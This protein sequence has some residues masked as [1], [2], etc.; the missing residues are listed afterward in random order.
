[1]G[2]AQLLLFNSSF[3]GYSVAL[4]GVILLFF[5]IFIQPMLLKKFNHRK[6]LIF[7]AILAFLCMLLFPSIYWLTF[8]WDNLWWILIKIFVVTLFWTICLGPMYVISSCYVNN[9]VPS[10]HIGKA[11]GI[12]Q[13]LAS[14]VRGCGPLLTGFIW[15]ESVMQIRNENKHYAVY[16]AYLPCAIIF[17]MMV[18]HAKYYIPSDL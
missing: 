14:F 6:I 8:V 5:N 12:G 3:I 16:F 9:S 13:T 7:S 10:Q 4:Q 1:M 2:M 18:F 11:N 15:S 17:V